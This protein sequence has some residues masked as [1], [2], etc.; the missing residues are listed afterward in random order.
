MSKNSDSSF[1]EISNVTDLKLR[2]MVSG[3]SYQTH[4]VS[5]IVDVPLKRYTKHVKSY[6]RDTVDFLNTLPKTVNLHTI[7]VSYPS[8]ESL[9][10]TIP[11]ELGIKAI[12][13]WLEN[14]KKNY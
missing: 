14:T 12:I 1:V 7:L 11:N 2:P 8:I 6:L 4:G 9:Y 13:Y 3:P 10:S 5:D